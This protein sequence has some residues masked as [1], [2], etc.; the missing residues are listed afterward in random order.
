MNTKTTSEKLN[1]LK[2]IVLNY[3]NSKDCPEIAIWCP[4]CENS[5]KNKL[6]MIVNVEKNLYHCFVCDTKGRSIPYLV[7]KLSEKYYSESK[8]YFLESSNHI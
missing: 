2:K 5:N 4:Y 1:F 7:K 6:K 3:K 8:N